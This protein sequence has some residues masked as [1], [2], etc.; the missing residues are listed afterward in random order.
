MPSVRKW[1]RQEI[2]AWHEKRAQGRKQHQELIRSLRE[3]ET[4]KRC[5]Y[6]MLELWRGCMKRDCRRARGC[7]GVFGFAGPPCFSPM[8]EH[9][10]QLIA[11]VYELAE[12]EGPFGPARPQ[13]YAIQKETLALARM[14]REAKARKAGKNFH[15]AGRSAHLCNSDRSSFKAG[16]QARARTIG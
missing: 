10:R 3:Q 11:A 9:D 1:T 6:D 13:L 14:Q 4:R 15:A 8:D 5:A 2:K 7:V 16:M 12:L